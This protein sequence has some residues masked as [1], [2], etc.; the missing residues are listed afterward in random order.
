MKTEKQDYIDFLLGKVPQAEVSGFDPPSPCHHSLF[1]HQM[2]ICEWAIRGGRRAIFASFG[3]GKTRMHLQLAKWVCEKTGGSF[4][5][6]CPLGVR[7]EFTQS[8]GPAM[9]M[10]LKFIRRNE[11]IEQP[12]IYVT[13]YE[14]V[15]DGKIDVNAFQGVGMDE[16]SVLRSFGSKTYQTFLP[17]FKAVPY[18]FVFTATPSPNRY[19]ELIHYGGFL[20]IM[21]TGEALTRFF[22]RDSSQANNLTLYPHME[23]QFWL[24]LASWAAFIQRPSDLGYSDLGYDLPQINVQWHRLQDD[25][26]KAWSK[27]DSWGQAQLLNDQSVGLKDS[28]ETKRETINKRIE[29]A[30]NL[31]DDSGTDTHWLVWHDLESERD[32]IEKHIQEAKT[33]YGSQ[34]LEK[35]EELIMGFTRGEYRI[36]AT[37]PIIAGSGCN[38][39]RH[40]HNAIFLGVGYKF[41]DLIQAI[42]RI[43][44]FQQPNQV[45]IHI[46]H[47]E[48]EDAIVEEL[49]AKWSRH[50]ELQKKMTAIMQEFKLSTHN[51]MEL[52]RTMLTGGERTEVKSKMFRSIRND[53]ILELMPIDCAHNL[54]HNQPHDGKTNQMVRGKQGSEE[55]IRCEIPSAECGKIEGQEAGILLSQ[56]GKTL[57]ESAQME[58][59]QPREKEGSGPQIHGKERGKMRGGNAS[60][61]S[62]EQ[63]ES[64]EGR[65]S[66]AAKEYI[67]ANNG[68]IPIDVQEAEGILPDMP[69]ENNFEKPAS[70]SLPYNGKSEGN[71]LQLMQLG[72]RS[73]QGQSREYEAGDKLHKEAW[74]DNCVDMILTSIPFGNQ[75]EYSPSFNDL[76]HNTDNDAFFDQM[77]FL[78]PNLLR[79][80]KPGRIAAIHV[81]DRIRFGNVTGDGFPTVDPFSDMTVAAFRK[82][83]FRFMARITIDTDVVRENNQTY[84]LGWSENAKDSSKMGAG[85]PEY[86]LIFRKL[87]SDQSNGYADVPVAKS[88]EDYTRADW[89]LDAAGLWRSNGN[90]L[91]D[92]EIMK[93]MSH[94]SIKATWIEYS[95]Q[96]GYSHEQ[97][98][99]LAKAL[100]GIGKLPS[101]FMLFPAISRNK[102]IWTDIARMRTL[103]SEQTRRNQE[104]HVCPLQLDIIKRLITRYSNKGEVVY[105]P[106]GGIGS[107]PFQALKMERHGWM[108]ELNE[109][110]WKDAV[111]YCEMAENEV[112][113]PTLFDLAA[114]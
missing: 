33:V 88:K 49:K 30:K 107:V 8:D 82:A 95:K 93:H 104:N 100:E 6:I 19:K 102:D 36:L 47:M 21:D 26:T 39:Q 40:C 57:G 68:E 55:S 22:Q 20:G 110:Y 67:R 51:S 109:D 13:N 103:N 83:G 89:Q 23:K 101:S 94:E 52:I 72:T 76:G 16:A 46:I 63:R 77:E 81:K 54:G 87:P 9:G 28:A 98:A 112:C 7:Q 71:S 24:W 5:I 29:F 48:S 25:H 85:M 111:G 79:V 96:G 45:N 114:I 62:K 108:T 90:R 80:L 17:L 50:E 38:F 69:R 11:E 59:F 74:P 42:H 4:L 86:V 66:P 32:L 27:V 2:D 106:F 15:R 12:G 3:L 97:H 61:V 91:P 18:R 10:S 41:N 44:R 35:R 84:R 37:K 58:G 99:E 78:C 31:I 43:H 75:Y 105:D 1:P 70:G 34:D 65:E 64:I 56:S 92:P 73:L 113:V 14:S 53:C 60:M